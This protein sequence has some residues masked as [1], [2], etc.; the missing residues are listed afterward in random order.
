[1]NKVDYLRGLVSEYGSFFSKSEIEIRGGDIEKT[2]ELLLRNVFAERKFHGYPTLLTSVYRPGDSGVH[3][4]GAAVDRILFK[5]GQYMKTP[6]DL[7]TAFWWM[8]TFPWSGSGLYLDWRFT[9]RETGEHERAPGLHSDVSQKGSRPLRWF[10]ITLTGNGDV[11]SL[12][13]MAD[14]KV[15]TKRYFFYQSIKDGKFYNA[16]LGRQYSVDGILRLWEEAKK[17]DEGEV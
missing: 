5:P 12:K 1:M 16:E 6:V 2:D 8:N 9:S 4:D 3:G 10:A 7:I 17:K 13:E 14:K 11:A 15:K